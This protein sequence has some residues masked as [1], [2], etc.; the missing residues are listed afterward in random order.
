MVRESYRYDGS[1]YAFFSTLQNVRFSARFELFER[2]RAL[3][4]PTMLVWGADDH[5]TPIDQLEPARRLL[6]P[7]RCHVIDDCGHMV[8]FERPREVDE[9]IASFS[10]PS[11][12]EPTS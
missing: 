5:V 1:L 3:G 12:K 10:A 11:A 4:L 6:Q 7:S 2:T 9:A 8:P